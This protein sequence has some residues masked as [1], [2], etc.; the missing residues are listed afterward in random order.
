MLY[1]CESLE[2]E[3]DDICLLFAVS[4]CNQFLGLHKAYIG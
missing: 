3:I 2:S 1:A 4:S